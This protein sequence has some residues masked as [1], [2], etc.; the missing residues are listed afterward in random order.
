VELEKT[1][2]QLDINYRWG[3][4]AHKADHRRCAE[5]VWQRGEKPARS[6]SNELVQ[7]IIREVSV[8]HFD[9]ETDPPTKE[10][11]VFKTKI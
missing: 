5:A 7:L 8:K 9:P 4:V 3:V 11:G 2:V 10:K 1:K 6:G